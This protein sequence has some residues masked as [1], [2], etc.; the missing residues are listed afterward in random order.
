LETILTDRI[1]S[2]FDKDLKIQ[3]TNLLL[4]ATSC[5]NGGHCVF[6]DYYKD[7]DLDYIYCKEFNSQIID[8]LPNNNGILGLA[9]SASIFEVPFESL[10][11]LKNHLIL[12]DF[13]YSE[14]QTETHWEYRNLIYNFKNMFNTPVKVKIGIETF[15]DN[16]RSRMGK[17]FK[18]ENYKHVLRY[19]DS[20]NMIVG[21]YCQT[22]ESVIDDITICGENFKYTDY[23]LIESGNEKILNKELIDWFKDEGQYIARGYGNIK[24]WLNCN[25]YLGD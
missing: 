14:I 16:I 19:S 18:I 2:F 15:N 21:L 7:T 4:K 9:P 8:K 23:N 12:N 24:V 5:L 6:C 10:I 1:F 22:K 20:V 13:V 25:E 11:Y 17:N 3:R